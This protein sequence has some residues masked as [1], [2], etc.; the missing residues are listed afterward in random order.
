MDA[1][2]LILIGAKEVR[3]EILAAAFS[4]EPERGD[5]KAADLPD[6][7]QRHRKFV[8]EFQGNGQRPDLG[9]VRQ[10]LQV[11]EKARGPQDAKRPCQR[12]AVLDGEAAPAR[13]A[14]RRRTQ[15]LGLDVGAERRALGLMRQPG[16][17]RFRKPQAERLGPALGGGRGRSGFA[18]SLKVC[19]RAIA[20]PPPSR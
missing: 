6:I 19:C 4:L 18:A 5:Q 3:R 10:L 2:M 7:L 1:D 20:W 14:A 15:N 11:T 8:P 9:E 16:A 13:G 12:R 17:F